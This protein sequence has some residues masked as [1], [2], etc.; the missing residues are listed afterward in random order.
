VLYTTGAGQTSPPSVDGQVWQA[1]GA[2]QTPVTAQL[3]NI[4]ISPLKFNAPVVY[5]GPVPSVVS[6]VQQFN[7]S[8]PPN[9]PPTF[10]TPVTNGNGFLSVTIGSQTVTVPIVVR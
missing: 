10:F 9:L 3:Q 8:I 2:L 7:I 4:N 6:A 5:A 1:P